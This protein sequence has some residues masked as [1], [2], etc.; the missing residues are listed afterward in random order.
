MILRL[1][2]QM[3]LLIALC[4]PKIT[5]FLLGIVFVLTLLSLFT[6]TV[7]N[8]FDSPILGLIAELFDVNTERNIPTIFSVMLLWTGAFLCALIAFIKGIR[9]ERYIIH[10]SLLSL[11]FV[12]L[13]WD[14]AVGIHETLNK[15]DL[16]K[17]FA[18]ILGVQSNGIF[19][20]D[21]LVVVLPI[22]FLIGLY[23]LKFIGSLPV[24]QRK[25]LIFAGCLYLSGTIVME[26]LGGWIWDNVSDHKVNFIYT[27]VNTLEEVLEMSGA[28]IFI[29]CLLLYL[30][31]YLDQITIN[32]VKGFELI[33]SAY[34][35]DD[36]AKNSFD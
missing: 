22:V 32:F 7:S 8:F 24:R 25:I 29:Y 17:T 11:I 6:T 1:V 26:M 5:K 20:F 18:K 28:I 33:K 16:S 9:N 35:I 15:S 27:L 10:W 13:G 12:F 19:T 23:Y 36:K 4:P 34:I 30:N 31:L 14:D 2:E 3:N 21:W